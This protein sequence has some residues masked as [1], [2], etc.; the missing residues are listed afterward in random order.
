MS[1]DDRHS[2][3]LEVELTTDPDEQG[4]REARNGLRQFDHAIEQIE[5]WLQPE[6]PFKLR[7]SAIMSLNRLALDGLS[8]YAG[9]YRLTGIVI[10]GSKHEPPPAYQVPEFVEEICDYVNTNWS[11]RSPIHLASYILWRLNWV[12]AFVDGNGRTT[13]VTSF[14]VLCV[15][16]GY[17]VPGSPTIPEQISHDKQPYYKA[18]EMADAA[19]EKEH[20]IDVGAMEDLVASHLAIQ[21]ASVIHAARAGGHVISPASPQA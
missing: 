7:P 10:K 4:R 21:I 9:I 5:Y 12:H 15:R 19:Y 13:R 17:R 8:S 3:A 1:S 20:R 18:L 2:E 11:S 16:L 14:V 6:R